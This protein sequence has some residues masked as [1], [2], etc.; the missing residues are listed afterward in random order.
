[1]E[2]SIETYFQSAN[3]ANYDSSITQLSFTE[4]SSV[5]HERL[6]GSIKLLQKAMHLLMQSQKLIDTR[7]ELSSIFGKEHTPLFCLERLDALLQHENLVKIHFLMI[8]Q[9]EEL[10]HMVDELKQFINV[11]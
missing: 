4:T 2:N 7:K 8:F 1:L 11:S 3:L 9:L 10:Q 5:M 6:D